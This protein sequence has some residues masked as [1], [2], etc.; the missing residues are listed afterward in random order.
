MKIVSTGDEPEISQAV[1]WLERLGITRSM[2]QSVNVFAEV[3]KPL[4]IQT[5]LYVDDLDEAPA[6]PEPAS[7]GVLT[8][9]IG[10]WG[11]GQPRLR[12][13]IGESG[14]ETVPEP[15]PVRR[16]LCPCGASFEHAGQGDQEQHADW[17][18]RHEDPR[19]RAPG[20]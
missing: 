17:I 16:D 11:P 10:N 5:T 13:D 20:Y 4:R 2:I 14:P 1:L 8:E 15:S 6:A 7:G 9:P 19:D 12:Y 3:G 18:D